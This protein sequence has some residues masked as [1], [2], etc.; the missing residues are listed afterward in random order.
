MSLYRSGVGASWRDRQAA[1][2]PPFLPRLAVVFPGFLDALVCALA[3]PL[4]PALGAFEPPLECEGLP[5]LLRGFFS[6][7]V[8]AGTV[9][10]SAHASPATATI[11]KIKSP[12]KKVKGQIKDL[13]LVLMMRFTAR[14]LAVCPARTRASTAADCRALRA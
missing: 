1:L 3:D 8:C 9:T 12:A 14:P 6:A 10:T 13:P 11:R 5:A 4:G 2:L 7:A